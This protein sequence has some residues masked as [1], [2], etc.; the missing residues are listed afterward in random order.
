MKIAYIAHPIGGDTQGNLEK[1]KEIGKRINIT[2]PDVVPFA[3][4]FF[5]CHAL[6]DNNSAH[7]ERGIKNDTELLKRGFI[8][9]MRLYGNRISS[10][11]KA[12]IKLAHELGIPIVPMTPETSIKYQEIYPKKS[13]LKPV[14][15]SKSNMDYR[16][17]VN[18]CQ[19]W[20]DSFDDKSNYREG[21]DLE[22]AVVETAMMEVFGDDV[23]NYI[24]Y[25][26]DEH[27]RNC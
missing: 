4:Y 16:N 20:L 7:R 18:A 1:L 19:N 15:K 10:G 13:V 5:D 17:I 21:D 12:E 14:Q 23:F 25:K 6:D 24:E 27:T 3:P 26:T 11:M 9:E 2:E 8:S 22:S